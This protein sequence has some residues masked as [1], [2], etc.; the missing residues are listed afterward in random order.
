MYY[1]CP[2]KPINLQ[3]VTSLSWPFSGQSVCHSMRYENKNIIVMYYKSNIHTISNKF[4]RQIL[5]NYEYCRRSWRNTWYEAKADNF[6]RLGL[7]MG[8][9]SLFVPLWLIWPRDRTPNGENCWNLHKKNAKILLTP[10][11]WWLTITLTS[12][13]RRKMTEVLRWLFFT[14]FLIRSLYS[15]L[16]VRIS[17][18]SCLY[19]CIPVWCRRGMG[20]GDIPIGDAPGDDPTGIPALDEVSRHGRLLGYLLRR[21]SSFLPPQHTIP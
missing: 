12:P 15:I 11:L 16:V 8:Y 19:L 6:L 1:L 2:G 7:Q 13:D 9:R 5:I 3:Q 14:S 10:N 4:V 20:L 17:R 18:S 21:S